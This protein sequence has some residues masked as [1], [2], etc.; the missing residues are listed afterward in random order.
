MRLMAKKKKT[1]EVGSEFV[2]ELIE[3]V[4]EEEQ[5]AF[6]AIRNFVESVDEA[7]PGG[8]KKGKKGEPSKRVE[9]V[10]AGLKMIEQLLGVS[11]D[12]ARRLTESVSQ[13]LPEIERNVKA[14]AKKASAKRPAKK[15]TAKKSTAK[16]STAKKS[17]AK[18]STAKKSTAK[19]STAKKSAAKKSTA[20][21]S[22]AKKSTAKKASPKRS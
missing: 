2:L 12:V 14:T 10:E 5:A 9:I 1:E 8:G 21:K 15:S 17:T 13:A 4:D 19:K 20:K 11:N 6:D 22:T 7:L 3:T 16:K 18:K